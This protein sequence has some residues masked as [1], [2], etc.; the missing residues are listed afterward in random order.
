[1]PFKI[2]KKELKAFSPTLLA[3]PIVIAITKI[4]AISD[5]DKAAFARKQIDRKKP[6]LI[7]AVSG[8]NIAELV[9]RLWHE[10]KEMRSASA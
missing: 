9:S 10:I 2:L 7:S 5:E 4:D 6:M 8:E 1:M 3:K